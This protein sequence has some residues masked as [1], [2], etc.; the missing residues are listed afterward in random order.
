MR[1]FSL[2]TIQH[3]SVFPQTNPNSLR[4]ARSLSR[5]GTSSTPR[6]LSPVLRCHRLHWPGLF[7]PSIILRVFRPS[8]VDSQSVP[9]TSRFAMSFFPFTMAVPL[10]FSLSLARQGRRFACSRHQVG[11]IAAEFAFRSAVRHFSR[12]IQRREALFL[13]N[14]ANNLPVAPR[15]L[16][17]VA[18]AHEKVRLAQGKPRA[19]KSR[20]QSPPQAKIQ[21]RFCAWPFR[22]PKHRTLQCSVA[23]SPGF[24]LAI[25]LQHAFEPDQARAGPISPFVSSTKFATAHHHC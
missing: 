19:L 15:L 17:L 13:Q 2:A 8:E 3:N 25:S 6:V 24:R 22:P 18:L 5:L 10:A 12:K 7:H 16:Q 11:F 1:F 20:A 4:K 23:K 14:T 9:D 21:V